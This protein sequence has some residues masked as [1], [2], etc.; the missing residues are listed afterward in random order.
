MTVDLNA[1]SIITWLAY[2]DLGHLPHLSRL[3]EIFVMLARQEA[4]QLSGDPHGSLFAADID[5]GVLEAEVAT[6][7]QAM[8][9]YSL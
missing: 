6:T 7:L 8:S 2:G 3:E 1:M 4:A 5:D 9:W